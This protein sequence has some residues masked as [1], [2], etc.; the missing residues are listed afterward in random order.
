MDRVY[1]AKAVGRSASPASQHAARNRP[2]VA[3]DG[4]IQTRLDA[5]VL[6]WR[7]ARAAADAVMFFTAK[8][9]LA[10]SACSATSFVECRKS[11]RIAAI[12][13]GRA[14]SLV[15]AFLRLAEPRRLLRHRCL[16][17]GAECNC[18]CAAHQSATGRFRPFRFARQNNF[19]SYHEP[20]GRKELVSNC[21][22]SLTQIDT[23]TRLRFST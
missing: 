14:L 22:R 9:S 21:N 11:R 6:A 13:P 19:S 17:C 15:T 10:M 23:R 7:P 5:H 12:C 8:S 20:D 1:L 4:A 16:L 18:R 3:K 2:A